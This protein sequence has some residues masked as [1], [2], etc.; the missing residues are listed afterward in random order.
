MVDKPLLY[1]IALSALRLNHQTS[2]PDND[3]TLAVKQLRLTYPLALSKALADMDLNKTATKLKLELLA[4]THPHWKYVYKY[5]VN[6]AKFRKIVSPFPV[7]NRETIIPSATEVVDNIDVILSNEPEAY[8]EIIASNVTLSALSP[9][10]AMA[11]GFQM[12]LMCPGLVVGKGSTALRQGI[13]NE[14][15]IYKAEAQED[16]SNENVDTTPD[17]FKSE[18]IMARLGGGRWHSGT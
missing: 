1:N 11:V 18:F 12:A 13:F 4:K 3:K 7:D 10:A 15:K 9:N 2:D 8:A 14:Y 17:E 5:P 6:C 16:D